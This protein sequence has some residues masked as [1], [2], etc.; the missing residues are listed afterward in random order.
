MYFISIFTI[1]EYLES[2]SFEITS[3]PGTGNE[4]GTAAGAGESQSEERKQKQAYD[5]IKT[6]EVFNDIKAEFVETLNDLKVK[7]KTLKTSC[8]WILEYLFESEVS[9]DIRK[10]HSAMGQLGIVMDL[11]RDHIRFFHEAR[12]EIELGAA[13]DDV[14]ADEREWKEGSDEIELSKDILSI[15]GQFLQ[16][17]SR[18]LES[19]GKFQPIKL[20]LEEIQSR[21]SPEVDWSTFENAL[22]KLKEFEKTL[23]QKVGNFYSIAQVFNDVYLH[24]VLET[25]VHM[26]TT[27]EQK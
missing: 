23:K 4:V 26:K 25:I 6:L 11:F 16:L 12:F 17:T 15:R 14:T 27:S 9:F 21:R 22:K 13:S 1:F 7:Q 3:S 24:D 19:V 10:F 2:D 20:K 5:V 18:L 8:E